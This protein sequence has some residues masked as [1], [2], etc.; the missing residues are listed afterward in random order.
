VLEGI[1]GGVQRKLGCSLGFSHIEIYT[2]VDPLK[3]I[4][5]S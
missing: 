2:A 4:V 5:N 3:G 1:N